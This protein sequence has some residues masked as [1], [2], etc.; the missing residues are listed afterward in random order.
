MPA[1]KSPS[2]GGKS[3]QKV[4]D[5]RKPPSQSQGTENR[6]FS[7]P[8]TIQL[9][10]LA[11]LLLVLTATYSPISQLTLSPVYGSVPSAAFH[12]RGMMV[13]AL[14]GWFAKDQ[15]RKRLSTKIMNVLPVLAFTI[16]TIQFFLFMRSAQLGVVYGPLLTEL[17]TYFPLVFLSVSS[18]AMLLEDAD[19]RRYGETLGNHGPFFG[20]YILFITLQKFVGILL[21]GY[22][23]KNALMAR[24]PLQLITASLYAIS[25]PSKWL[26]LA[27][28][29]L[30]FSSGYNVHFPFKHTT[31]LLNSTLQAEDFVLLHREESLTGYLSVLEN[32]KEHYRVMRCDHSLLGG[33]WTQMP[34]AQYPEVREPIY[35]IFTMLEAVRLIKND[36]GSSRMGGTGTNSLVVGLGIGTTPTALVN[37]GIDTT[38]VEI[39]PA[40][41]HLAEDYFSL[42]KNFTPVI[43]DAVKFVDEASR[44]T[45]APTF[46]Y[47]VHDVF[48]GG[49]E[50]VSLFT[51]EFM[52][53][54]RSLLKEDGVIAI[55]YAGD[56]TLPSSGLIVR[57]IRAVFPSCRIFRESEPPADTREGDFTN[58]VIF[59]KLTDS[60]LEFRNTTDADFLG[61]KS[62]EAYLMPQLEIDAASFAKAEDGQ[63]DVL[64]EGQVGDLVRWHSQSAA[65]HWSIMRTVLP[66]VIWE[67]W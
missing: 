43:Q 64:A 15:I 53:G 48:T 35:S 30:L 26:L 1:R 12:Q 22:I 60:P 31:A 29:P 5:K 3:A 24:I 58:M 42:P 17:L 16:P 27:L 34:N 49:V 20:S 21:P 61:S 9:I 54:L 41:L 51:I 55:N 52:K 4:E 6:V 33:E 57:T 19:L 40:V 44:A 8:K 38:V 56:L 50:P 11:I 65:G 36:D 59:C 46:D 63:Q 32:V 45:P 47:I 23:G 13:A 2:K 25:L 14:S 62:R 37:H 66:H 7:A 10:G 39:D 28:P 18:V 67:N